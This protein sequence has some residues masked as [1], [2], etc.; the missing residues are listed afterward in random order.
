MVQNGGFC[1]LSTGVSADGYL[2]GNDLGV[3]SY[4]DITAEMND[5]G[6]YTLHFGSCEARTGA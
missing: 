5:D 4:S 6:S 3:N 1:F 2:E